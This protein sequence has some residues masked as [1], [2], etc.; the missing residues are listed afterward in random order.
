MILPQL[1][2][3]CA[4]ARSILKE[5][6]DK[7]MDRMNQGLPP[8]NNADLILPNLWLGNIRASQDEEFLRRNEIDTVFNCTKDIPFHFSV[9]RRYRVPVDDNLE[10][11]EIRNLELW[12][13][14]VVYKLLMEYKRGK[15]ILVH[16]AAGMQ[17]SAAVVAM[18]LIA[19]R[20]MK[21]EDAI[22]FIRQRRPIAFY[23][24]ANFLK[25]IQGFETTLYRLYPTDA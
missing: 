18:F 12:S 20:G 7:S 13:F 3:T 1:K 11:E 4:P 19:N 9:H 15:P 22:E 14:E 10:A 8:F 24:Q 25:S 17:R 21:H 23:G 5:P 2:F 16:C 6:K